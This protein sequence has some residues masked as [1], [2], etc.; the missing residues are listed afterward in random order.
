MRDGS[1]TRLNVSYVVQARVITG[2]YAVK[3]S[4][5]LSKDFV[6]QMQAIVASKAER[7]VADLLAAIVAA[8]V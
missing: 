4:C 6:Q 2:V 5:N 3:Q 1:S 8:L 7:L